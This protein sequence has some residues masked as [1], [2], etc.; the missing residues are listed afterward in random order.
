MAKK[1][2]G[3]LKLD[4][5]DYIERVGN[6][7]FDQLDFN[8]ID[9]LVFSIMSYFRFD[10][11]AE[12]NNELMTITEARNILLMY[13][14]LIAK[15]GVNEYRNAMLAL[16]S[17]QIRYKDL[18][19]FHYKRVFSEELEE[20]FSALCIRLN[21]D[22]IYVSYSGTDSTLTGRK[23]DFN[24]SY[25]KN[26]PSQLTGVKYINELKNIVKK[27]KHIYV[28]GHSKGGNLALYSAA[29][30]YPKI[31]QKIEKVFNFDGPGF[32]KLSMTPEIEEIYK[33]T[34]SIVPNMSVIG[35]IFNDIKELFVIESYAKGLIQHDCFT[36]KIKDNNFVY[37]TYLSANS[38][39]MNKAVNDYVEN[40]SEEERKDF[41]DITWELV[42]SCEAKDSDDL[43]KNAVKSMLKMV[44]KYMKLPKDK[45]E[46]FK[47]TL[48]YLIKSFQ[49]QTK[50]FKD[51]VNYI[52]YGNVKKFEHFKI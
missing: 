14:E 28:G 20:Q 36:W 39:C 35:I 49:S 10:F 52:R 23:E 5:F 33:K 26:I 9:A 4:L 8:I 24:M 13:P 12:K 25:Q 17:K 27:T 42:E 6:K 3:V 50:N 45:K 32:S 37:A 2:S 7:R 34:I 46:F 19:L 44:N 16:I 31:N 41:L 38:R 43:R 11:M 51:E 30:A 47:K 21:S 18:T 48:F 29:H 15:D 22:T 40:L 1:G